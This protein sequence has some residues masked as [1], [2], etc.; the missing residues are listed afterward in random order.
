MPGSP[1]S[2]LPSERLLPSRTSP[3]PTCGTKSK[4]VSLFLVMSR[5]ASGHL[6]RWN[7]GDRPARSERSQ[8]ALGRWLFGPR[9]QTQRC[10]RPIRFG[11]HARIRTGDLFLTKEMLCHL[12]YVGEPQPKDTICCILGARLM[13]KIDDMLMR[14]RG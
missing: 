9:R 8:P 10:P 7:C 6:V 14:A 3:A 13:A 11:A 2:R 1:S 5:P 12:S 4:T